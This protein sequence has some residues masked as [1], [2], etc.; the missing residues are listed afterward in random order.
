MVENQTG[1]G[2]AIVFVVS[3]MEFIGVSPRQGE[4]VDEVVILAEDSISG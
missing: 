1:D 3:Q 4:V 2:K